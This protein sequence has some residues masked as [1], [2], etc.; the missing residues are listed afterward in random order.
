MLFLSQGYKEGWGDHYEEK[1]DFRECLNENMRNSY[2]Q[3]G[4]SLWQGW[5]WGYHDVIRARD[6]ECLSVQG[7]ASVIIPLIE[8]TSGSSEEKRFLFA[9]KYFYKRLILVSL[10]LR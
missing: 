2:R 3:D 6:F 5:F 7:G 4:G 1:F 9:Q 10:D 8:E